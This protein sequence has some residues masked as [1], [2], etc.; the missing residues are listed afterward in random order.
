M[1]EPIFSII[2]PIYGVEK[3]LEKC[4]KSILEQDFDDFELILVDD[5]SPDKCPEIVDEYAKRDKRIRVIHKKNEGLVRARNSGLVVAKGEY[6]VN[7]DGDDYMM[8]GALRC[9]YENICKTHADVYLF[10]FVNGDGDKDTLEI[11]DIPMGLYDEKSKRMLYEKIIYDDKKPFFCFGTYPSVWSRIVKRELFSEVRLKIDYSLDIGEDFAT[12]LPIMLRADKI[13]FIPEALYYYRIIESSAS[14]KFNVNEMSFFS[15]M[16]KG[17][18][19]SGIDLETFGI[20]SQLGA[21]T[22]YVFY[23][24]LC[25]YIRTTDNYKDYI[26]KINET[27]EIIFRYAGYG[28]YNFKDRRAVIMMWI[29]KNRMWRTLWIYAKKRG[30]KA[31]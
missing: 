14:H 27:E 15:T 21:Y 19:K 9:L 1:S 28:R 26:E 20:K 12:T 2:V 13:C 31:V 24:Y 3:Y 6:I 23:N 11:P 7:V 16:L 25:A 4:I 29:I 17:F 8:S 10:G 30:K 5:G 22:I 18:E